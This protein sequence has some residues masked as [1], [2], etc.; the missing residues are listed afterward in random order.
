MA[1]FMVL[2]LISASQPLKISCAKLGIQEGN[3]DRNLL[4]HLPKNVSVMHRLLLTTLIFMK[5]DQRGMI[6]TWCKDDE[7]YDEDI[8][9]DRKAP[10]TAL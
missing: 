2:Y 9:K 1:I 6:R 8:K 3:L 5:R 7:V 4:L 10:G